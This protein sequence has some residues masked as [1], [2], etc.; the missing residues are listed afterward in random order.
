M[1]NNMFNII[2]LNSTRLET[3]SL[4]Q[5]TDFQQCENM[6]RYRIR[7]IFRARCKIRNI[8]FAKSTRLQTSFYAK[9]QD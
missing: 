3:S 5:I 8:F 6:D 9:V 1:F 2:Y 7:N 4:L